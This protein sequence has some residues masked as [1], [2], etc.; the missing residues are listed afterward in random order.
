LRTYTLPVACSRLEFPKTWA[1]LVESNVRGQIPE[2]S[3]VLERL[4]L[5]SYTVKLW[6]KVT[7]LH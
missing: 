7:R 6:F 2:S 5:H 4:I 3:L 1:Y